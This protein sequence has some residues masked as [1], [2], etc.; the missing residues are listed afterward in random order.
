MIDDNGYLYVPEK[1]GLGCEVDEKALA[2]YE[3]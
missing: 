1:P 2:Q 3:I